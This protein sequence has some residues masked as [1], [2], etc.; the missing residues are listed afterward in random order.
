MTSTGTIEKSPLI[1]A[2]QRELEIQD[3]VPPPKSDSCKDSVISYIS[4]GILGLA[5]IGAGYALRYHVS[6]IGFNYVS[7]LYWTTRCIRYCWFPD[8]SKNAQVPCVE[9]LLRKTDAILS[10]VLATNIGV[11][12][13]SNNLKSDLD[14]WQGVN[15]VGGAAVIAAKCATRDPNPSCCERSDD[16]DDE[17]ESPDE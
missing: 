2:V 6:E 11:T 15:L 14:L 9:R 7:S 13:F 3:A 8:A 17:V 12:A 5:G 16:S 10:G 4:T 1:K